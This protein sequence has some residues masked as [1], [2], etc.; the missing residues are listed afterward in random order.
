[1]NPVSGKRDRVEKSV[2]LTGRKKK[3]PNQIKKHRFEVF[4]VRNV[5]RALFLAHKYYM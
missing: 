5:E 3:P 1:M 2:R 4:R